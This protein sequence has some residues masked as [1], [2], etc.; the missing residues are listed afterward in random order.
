[1]FKQ[2][3]FLAAMFL[4]ICYSNGAYSQV[5]FSAIIDR[6]KYIN[7]SDLSLVD[8][9]KNYLNSR[10]CPSKNDLMTLDAEITN[11]IVGIVLD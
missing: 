5:Q 4:S 9:A 10:S 8:L 7:T 3:Y 2:F 11:R 6:A 1:M